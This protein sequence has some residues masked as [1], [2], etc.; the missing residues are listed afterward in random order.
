MRALHCHLGSSS[1]SACAG[2]P[3]SCPLGEET[4][5]VHK[6]RSEGQQAEGREGDWRVEGRGEGTIEGLQTKWPI[7]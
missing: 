4:L 7:S 5:G 3:A 2:D 6:V 1:Q